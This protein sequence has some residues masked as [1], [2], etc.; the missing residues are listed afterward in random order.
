MVNRLPLLCVTVYRAT[1]S[2]DLCF[3]LH[4]VIP[5]ILNMY[6]LVIAQIVSTS[7]HKI[8][9]F[10]TTCELCRMT[11]STRVFGLVHTVQK[12]VDKIGD[13]GWYSF[14]TRKGFITTIEEKSK[15]KNWKYNFFFAHRADGWLTFL[16]RIR[17][18]L[19]GTPLVSPLGRKEQ[20]PSTSST[21]FGRMTH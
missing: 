2:Y 7:R 15:L 18:V 20:P 13:L 19:L 3:P 17:M 16:V 6:E 11:C 5:G 21:M 4:E 9:C 10:V 1:L 14:N 12:S 8:Y